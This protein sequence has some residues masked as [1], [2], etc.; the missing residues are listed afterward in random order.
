MGP[1]G[2]AVVEWLAQRAL[3]QPVERS[4]EWRRRSQIPIFQIN[5]I[6]FHPTNPIPSRPINRIRF[7]P[8]SPIRFRRTS[9]IRFHPT[10]RIRIQLI[11]P[12]QTRRF[13]IS[14]TRIQLIQPRRTRRFRINPIQIR[15]IRIIPISRARGPIQ[16]SRRRDFWSARGVKASNVIPMLLERWRAV[17]R[18]Q[19]AC[20]E[21][22]E[23]RVVVP[24]SR[25][26]RPTAGSFW[27][28]R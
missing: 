28:W 19:M 9:P 20:V 1:L 10:N 13:R 23:R 11:R 14:L 16:Q 21:R 3:Q 4:R 8:I 15:R 26:V 12:R 7:R 18:V 2:R 24:S 6:R 17:S 5:P 25:R 27:S 22:S